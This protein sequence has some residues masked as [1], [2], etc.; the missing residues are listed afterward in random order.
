ML[1][2]D[3]KK[4]KA[5]QEVSET[6]KNLSRGLLVGVEMAGASEVEVM[7]VPDFLAS[8]DMPELICL[9]EDWDDLR[10]L[11]E[12]AH[13]SDQTVRMAIPLLHLDFMVCTYLQD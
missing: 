6:V 8:I 12:S 3:K 4:L 9:M 1:K 10:V 5:M 2:N 13:S 7:T 11:A